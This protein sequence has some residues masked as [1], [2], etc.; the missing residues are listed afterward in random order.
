MP[1]KTC[2]A[3]K[4]S[5][6]LSSANFV[7]YLIGRFKLQDWSLPREWLLNDAWM[8]TKIDA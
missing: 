8:V 1:V 4:T 5:L 2:C 3:V 7:R 6:E